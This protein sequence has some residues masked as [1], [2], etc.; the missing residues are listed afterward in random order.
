LSNLNLFYWSLFTLSVSTSGA[1]AFELDSLLPANV[2][3]YG[4]TQRVSILGRIDP[5]YEPLDFNY[6]SLSFSPSI[7]GGSGYDSN[8][9]G[10]SSGSATFN[11]NPSLTAADSELGFG[12]YIA[13]AFST[14]P[15]VTGQNTSGYAAAL[16]ERMLLPRETLT[17]A[18]ASINTQVTGFGFNSIAFSQPVTTAVKD[19]RGS[20][21]IVL[22]M[23]TLIPECSVSRY[24]FQG[25]PSQDRTDYRQ[26]VTGEFTSGGPVRLVTLLQATES[27]YQQNA[28]NAN[29]YGALAGIADEA[30]GLWQIRLLAGAASR[31]PAVG[32]VMTEPVLEG[33]LDWMPT[34]IDSLSLDLAREI[35]D[36][37]QESAEGYTV[38][39]AEISFAHEYLRNVIITGSG[40]V[41]RAVYFNSSLTE[42]LVNVLLSAN[43]HLNRSLSVD[44]TYAFNDRQANELAAANEN[45]ITMGVTWTP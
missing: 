15:E 41:S 40:K 14:Y 35:D 16:G 43:W 26:S 37:E 22:G 33:S 28:F 1:A 13:G 34:E 36:P 7:N 39:A 10:I 19:I 21:K 3:G 23:L 24:A 44:A 30:T 9:N 45:I 8:P 17:L 27:Q 38:S 42:T 29:T 20:D 4:T 31:Q 11:L 2:P 32:K 25:Y 18:V 6:G 5:E 12:A